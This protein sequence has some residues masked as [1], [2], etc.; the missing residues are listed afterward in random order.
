MIG[1]LKHSYLT[2]FSPKQKGKGQNSRNWKLKKQPPSRKKLVAHK[3]QKISRH[4]TK[5]LKTEKCYRIKEQKVKLVQVTQVRQVWLGLCKLGLVW[6]S[7]VR[8]LVKLGKLGLGQVRLGQ[9]KLSYFRYVGLG[10]VKF[11]FLAAIFCNIVSTIFH[12]LTFWPIY[13][14][15]ASGYFFDFNCRLFLPSPIKKPSQVVPT[16]QIDRTAI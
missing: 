7:Q 16:L 2:I 15:F 8:F 14:F 9:F 3:C 12:G 6:F 1:L 5:L 4:P 11:P 10:K 13:T